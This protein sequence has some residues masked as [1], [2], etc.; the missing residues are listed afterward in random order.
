MAVEKAVL[1]SNEESDS[2]AQQ[3]YSYVK[4][5]NKIKFKKN[6]NK[7]EI[8]PASQKKTKAQQRRFNFPKELGLR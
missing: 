3:I 2:K 5:K 7:T 4:F 6:K 1:I 8:M